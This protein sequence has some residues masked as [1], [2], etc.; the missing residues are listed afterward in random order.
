M[1]KRILGGPRSPDR[2]GPIARLLA[3]NILKTTQF[4]TPHLCQFISRVSKFQP[5]RHSVKHVC[6]L[7]MPKLGSQFLRQNRH[8]ATKCS[9][10]YVALAASL[11][12]STTY[13]SK[14]SRII[15]TFTPLFGKIFLNSMNGFLRMS[16]L[17]P[18]P[19]KRE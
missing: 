16:T 19:E 3:N 17:H 8:W 12:T 1:R 2:R 15:C 13:L 5:S 6:S 9:P 11:G 4:Y 18:P 7:L 14:A 10:P